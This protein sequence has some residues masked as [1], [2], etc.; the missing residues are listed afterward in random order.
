MWPRRFRLAH[1]ADAA[2]REILA[3][4]QKL[5]CSALMPPCPQPRPARR[6]SSAVPGPT[7]GRDG[8]RGGERERERGGKGVRKLGSPKMEAQVAGPDLEWEHGTGNAENGTQSACTGRRGQRQ[9]RSHAKPAGM[10]PGGCLLAGIRGG[11][12]LA[13][14]VLAGSQSVRQLYLVLRA[15]HRKQAARP[16]RLH[17]HLVFPLSTSQT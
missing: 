8:G 12:D 15:V 1:S 9:G 7:G 5:H 16:A 2:N 17:L 14:P 3:A 4:F 6:I 11:F 13:G 10:G